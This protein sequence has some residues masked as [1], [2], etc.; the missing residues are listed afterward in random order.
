MTPPSGDLLL[1]HHGTAYFLRWLSLIGDVDFDDPADP[2]SPDSRRRIAATVGYDARGFARLAEG[3]REHGATPSTFE[4]AAEREEQI[5]LGESLPPRALRYLVAHAAIHLSV[6]WRDL[7]ADH[8]DGVGRDDHGDPIAV[9][10]TPWLRAQQVW[11]SAVDLGS[12]ASFVDFPAKLL[13][14]LIVD[15]LRDSRGADELVEFKRGSPGE[16]ST[17]R[18]DDLVACGALPD[19]ARWICHRGDRRVEFSD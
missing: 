7:S 12:G 6:E 8:W 11:L 16:P 4:S 10:A 18:R 17:I 1:A 9:S 5:V 3:F 19:L 14:R 13:E 2:G 15:R